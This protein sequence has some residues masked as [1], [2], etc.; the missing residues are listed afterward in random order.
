VTS[1]S[2]SLHTVG[3]ITQVCRHSHTAGHSIL[4]K[5]VTCILLK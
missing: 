1:D 4:F 2:N 3:S 5:W